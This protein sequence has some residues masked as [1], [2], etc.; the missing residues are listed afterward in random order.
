LARTER[1]GKQE[2][3]AR[4]RSPAYHDNHDYDTDSEFTWPGKLWA[5]GR[6]LFRCDTNL[7]GPGLGLLKEPSSH[8]REKPTD[9]IGRP[10]SE[11]LEMRTY[12]FIYIYKQGDFLC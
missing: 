10:P 12:L 11:I 8:D 9:D 1:E 2:P 7:Y 4:G 5:G 3:R 6:C